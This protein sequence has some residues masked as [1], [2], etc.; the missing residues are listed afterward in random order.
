MV[1]L[2]LQ[3][4]LGLFQDM[5]EELFNTEEAEDTIAQ[6]SY[7]TK[8]S[9]KECQNFFLHSKVSFQSPEEFLQLQVHTSRESLSI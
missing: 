9:N 4:L 6:V 1:S 2:L 3:T 7:G 8:D 5:K